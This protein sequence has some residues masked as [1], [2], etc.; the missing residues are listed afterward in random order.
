MAVLR[1]ARRG[2]L[3][4]RAGARG[5]AAHER[6]GPPRR[7]ARGRG[8]A[9]PA[10][11]AAAALDRRVDVLGL[12]VDRGRGRRQSLRRPAVRL[13]REPR[14][15]VPRSGVARHDHRVRA[16][17]HPALRARRAP[18]GVLAR[19]CGVDLQGARRSRRPGRDGRR[20]AHRP[21]TG[22]GG[23]VRGLEPGARRPRRG[24]RAQ[25]RARRRA[26]RAGRG[27]RGAAPG[28]ARRRGVGARRPRQVGTARLLRARSAGG[29]LAK[30]P[31][32]RRRVRR[33]RS[34]SS[35]ASPPGGTGST[36]WA[37][38]AR[39]PTTRFAVRATR[40]PR[41]SSSSERPR[42]WRSPSPSGRW[43]P[44]SLWLARDALR[45][46][47]HLGRAACL[48]LAT[49]PYLAVWYLA[50]AVP[51]AAP[52]EDRLARLGVLALTAYLLPQTI[53]L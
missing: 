39:S 47:A 28:L 34:R 32:G 2:L 52:E 49:S 9:R 6:P 21:P 53:P 1:P 11:R 33:R 3:D 8:A 40:F 42:A 27:A 37:R 51:L 36:G 26:R 50:W 43:P 13:P 19:R 12:R 18:R 16:G 29:T 48:V 15:A 23:R 45:G 44:A 41:G 38:S 35:S 31:G 7:R 30:P 17:V 14:G 46:R 10:L 22:S 20:R 25:R 5:D 24:R 4:L